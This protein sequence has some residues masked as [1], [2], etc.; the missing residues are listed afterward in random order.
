[1][2]TCALRAKCSSFFLRAQ[3]N[4]TLKKLNFKISKLYGN[5]IFVGDSLCVDYF[6]KN[7]D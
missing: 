2:L 7:N 5:C 1:M 3:V 6:T 4:M